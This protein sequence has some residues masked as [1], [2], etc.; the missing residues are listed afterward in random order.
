MRRNFVFKNCNPSPLE[1]KDC[2]R[3]FDLVWEKSPS[4]SGVSAVVE[5]KTDGSFMTTIEIFSSLAKFH[6][7]ASHPSISLSAEYAVS[8]VLDSYHEWRIGRF[9]PVL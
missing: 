7:S 6:S 5:K 1:D 3:L 2:G 9:D 8:R 4:D